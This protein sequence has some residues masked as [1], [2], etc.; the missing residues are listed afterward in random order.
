[1][2]HKGCRLKWG[3]FALAS[4]PARE[5]LRKA[6]QTVAPGPPWREYLDEAAFRLTQ[7]VREG[8]PIVTLTGATASP[9][10]EL[11]PNMLY[12]GEPTLLYADGDTGKSL[13]GVALAVATRSGRALP[14]GLRPARAVPTA[15]LDWETS[16]QTIETR[17]SLVATGLEIP[18]PAIFYKP[19]NRPLV[20]EAEQLATEFSRRDVGFVVIDSM[21][22]ALKGGEGV[23]FHDA[24]TAFYNALRLFSP[25]A[26]LVLSHV[27]NDAARAGGPAR[28]FGGAFAFNGPRLAWEAKRDQEVAGATALTF[29]CRKANNLA[30]RPDPFGLL[31]EPA[32]GPSTSAS[33]ICARPRRVPCPASACPNAFVLPWPAVP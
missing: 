14:C 7:A 22:F 26:T 17:G 3:A 15:I 2:R 16:R 21:I 25:A 6:L 9:A 12:E 30:Q 24:S 33:S 4:I 5:S 27:T 11:V 20:D 23:G 32:P 18:T 10:R 29:T 1:M 13:F 31:F 8:S 19:M 28:S